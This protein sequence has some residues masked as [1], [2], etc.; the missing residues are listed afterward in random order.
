MGGRAVGGRA[1]RVRPGAVRGATID[2]NYGRAGGLSRARVA[3]W[4]RE[5]PDAM[6]SLLIW[7]LALVAVTIILIVIEIFLPTA[8]IVGA[9]AGVCGI[10]G[11]VC[12]SLHSWQWGLG[13]GLTLLVLVPLMLVFGMQVF[14][15][16]PLGRRLIHG[17]TGEPTTVLDPDAPNPYEKLMGM[18]GEVITDL[19]P[20]GMIRIAGE[21]YSAMSE[22]AYVSAGKQVKVVSVQ[23]QQIRVR[24]V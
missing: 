10:G 23:D 17:S 6:E 1:G 14:P 22:V 21:K 3:V 9:L 4:E 15:H 5:E 11:V 24:P 8:G 16:T 18:Q 19:R 13:G 20:V 12:L 7:G 2:A